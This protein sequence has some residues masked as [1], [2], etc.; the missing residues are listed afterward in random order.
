HRFF[1]SIRDARSV[2]LNFGL[3][4]AQLGQNRDV[5]HGVRRQNADALW[6]T[7]LGVRHQD[8]FDEPVAIVT[9]GRKRS[10]IE[11]T[12]EHYRSVC[13]PNEVVANDPYVS[14]IT[15]YGCA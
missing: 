4:N 9:G 8:F 5:Q 6:A 12:A 10:R 11:P 15:D 1:I 2:A 13:W 7:C 3:G 14:S